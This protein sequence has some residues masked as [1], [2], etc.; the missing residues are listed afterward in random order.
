MTV[1]NLQ[2]FL[3]LLAPALDATGLTQAASKSVSSS[4]ESLSSALEP[5]KDLHTDQLS[6]LLR[7]ADHL[8]RTGALPDWL[9]SKKPASRAS[10]P[11][12]PKTPRLTVPEAVSLLRDLERR[13]GVDPSEIS[14]TILRLDSLTA[15]D[16]KEVQSQFLGAVHGKKKADY[17][18]ALQK[19]LDDHHSQQSRSRG[20]LSW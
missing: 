4:L 3:R 16:L 8:Q 18:A 7:A 15:S 19:R 6:D 12:A 17:L 20:I 2:R 14:S 11:K 13:S 5:F 10:T 9:L 1:S